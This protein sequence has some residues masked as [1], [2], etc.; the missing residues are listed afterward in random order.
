[1]A[2]RNQKDATASSN[3][4]RVAT[5]ISMEESLQVYENGENGECLK[6]IVKIIY[7]Y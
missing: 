1:V 5:T 4:K 6:K 2:G 7:Y 3:C